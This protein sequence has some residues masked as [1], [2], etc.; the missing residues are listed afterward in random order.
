[1]I[2]SV[3]QA[4][5]AAG[6]RKEFLGTRCRCDA[7]GKRELLP[8]PG[9][10]AHRD[11]RTGAHQPPLV[12]ERPSEP[13]GSPFGG[14]TA[15][16]GQGE[17]DGGPKAR[18]TVHRVL[19][20]QVEDG[21]V[22]KERGESGPPRPASRP[23]SLEC[24]VRILGRCS[25]QRRTG[26]RHLRLGTLPR[27]FLPV[28]A[29]HLTG[30]RDSR[31]NGVRGFQV[32]RICRN[33]CAFRERRGFCRLRIDGDLGLL[34]VGGGPTLISIGTMLSVVVIGGRLRLRGLS[35]DG[36][37]GRLLR[38]V[39]CP[40]LGFGR[41]DLRALSALSALLVVGWV[42]T[43]IVR[44]GSSRLSCGTWFPFHQNDHIWVHA[45]GGGLRPLHVPLH[46][47]AGSRGVA[48]IP[49]L[50]P[51]SLR[52]PRDQALLLQPAQGVFPLQ[53]AGGRQRRRHRRC[54]AAGRGGHPGDGAGQQRPQHRTDGRRHAVSRRAP[55]TRRLDQSP[56]VPPALLPPP[57]VG[58]ALIGQQ[59]GRGGRKHGPQQQETTRGNT[60]SPERHHDGPRYY[61][62]QHG[63]PS[64]GGKEGQHRR[65]QRPAGDTDHGEDHLLRLER[66]NR[67]HS[68]Q[69]LK[70][71]PGQS[72]DQQHQAALSAR[73]RQ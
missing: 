8:L 30:T 33:L 61:Q 57:I 43:R 6:G 46:T 19:N 67:L 14:S 13:E 71:K 12:R 36:P 55:E 15:V 60:L 64:A 31:R 62:R 70:I 35:L 41:F 49:G 52:G 63:K 26:S 40:A 58:K 51:A 42:H 68:E 50:D 10:L 2:S 25:V 39:R 37:L 73:E 59:E 17:I 21:H 32:F 4:V 65:K 47:A 11:V 44:L 38:F 34:P 66:P 28:Y 5:G 56:H 16:I 72:G 23:A 1:M 69:A 48:P 22:Y 3:Q 27:A 54:G 53:D 9:T 20:Y 29:G 24:R 18:P 7:V 45:C